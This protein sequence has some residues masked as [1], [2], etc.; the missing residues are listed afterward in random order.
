MWQLYY[1][2]SVAV[3]YLE[4]FASEQPLLEKSDETICR[5]SPFL[6]NVDKPSE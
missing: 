4:H 1:L 5:V 6:A 3:D 2:L